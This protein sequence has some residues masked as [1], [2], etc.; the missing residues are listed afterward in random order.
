[1][2]QENVETVRTSWEAWMKGDAT[3]LLAVLH[4]EIVYE[5]DLLPDH[6]GETYRGVEGLVRAWT[7]WTEPWEDFESGLEWVRD[8]GRD[9]VVSC[10]WARMRGKGSGIPGEASYAYVWRFQGSKIVYCKSFG[11]PSEALKAV[12]LSG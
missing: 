4:P 12:G 11:E 7:S 6:A 3:A 2:S 5:D 8:A 9:L 1:M 10:H